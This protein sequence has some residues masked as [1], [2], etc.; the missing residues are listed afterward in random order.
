M[1]GH[2]FSSA[3]AT[4]LDAYVEFKTAMGCYGSSRIWYLHKFDAYC[5]LHG[6]TVLDQQTVE[7]WVAERLS[8]SGR[9]RS[10][11]SYIRDFGRFLRA[12]GHPD[13]YVLSNR[14]KAGAVP[15]HPYLLTEREIGA[16]FTAAN[17][18]ETTS[19]WRWQATAFFTL[20][21]CLG[22]RTGEV[23]AL[24]REQVD[25]AGRRVDVMW[26]KGRRSRR[27]PITGD[28]SAILTACDRASSAAI[29]PGRGTFF[30]SR[31]GQPVSSATTGVMFNRIWDAADLPRT[32]G[33]QP[34]PYAFRHHFAYANVQRWAVAG[35]DV[36]AMLPYLS[37]F[38][39]H[40]TIES[41]FY[42]IH[43]SPDFMD[44]YADLTAAAGS[45]LPEVGFE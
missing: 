2:G 23:R 30:V 44:G 40:A 36:M 19:P 28:V 9:Y 18:L 43:T 8:T 12:T 21:H 37:A 16:F 31:T 35:V 5:A 26:S 3:L 15:P 42:Y 41:T 32:R 45:L 13:A 14:W 17:Q 20:M 4:Q 7:A 6:R 29:G 11:M 25:P 38:M 1:N 39:G 27:L 10:W 34:G 22:L 24:R 33:K